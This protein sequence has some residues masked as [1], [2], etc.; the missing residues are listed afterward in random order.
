[1][2]QPV[3]GG[4]GGP[5][6]ALEGVAPPPGDLLI[7]PTVRPLEDGHHDGAPVVVGAVNLFVAYTF[8]EA[9]WVKFKLFGMLGLTIV[10]VII[11]SIWLTLATQKNEATEDTEA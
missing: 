1:M 9:F 7:R 4:L 2:R 8:S 10:F 3:R 5:S 6:A 11:Q